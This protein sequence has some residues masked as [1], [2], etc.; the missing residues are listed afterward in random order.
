[1]ETYR[2]ITCK[3]RSTTPFTVSGKTITGREGK[4][5]F[6]PLKDAMVNGVYVKGVTL[7]LLEDKPWNHNVYMYADPKLHLNIDQDTID[8]NKMFYSSQITGNPKF[9]YD[10][11]YVTLKKEYEGLKYLTEKITTIWSSGVNQLYPNEILYRLGGHLN[12]DITGYC[13][14]T[15]DYYD[16]TIFQAVHQ[17]SEFIQSKGS[18]RRN[19]VKV[20]GLT[21]HELVAV[22]TTF[23]K[24]QDAIR[25]FI[26]PSLCAKRQ[27][28]LGNGH[29]DLILKRWRKLSALDSQFPL[30]IDSDGA[31]TFSSHPATPCCF[32]TIAW[33]TICLAIVQ[34]AKYHSDEIII[35]VA[36]GYKT[37]LTR[38]ILKWAEQQCTTTEA[39][40][41]LQKITRYVHN[42]SD[43]H[44]RILTE[45]PLPQRM[46]YYE[47][48][49][50]DKPYNE[51]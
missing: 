49:Y 6:D 23:W 46:R 5:E 17:L 43:E 40:E 38:D 27:P 32:R 51:I 10:K 26:P 14:K 16:P 29:D 13:V 11:P 35:S 12:I 3:L 33:L 37:S 41:L 15:K 7:E 28:F 47:D 2:D 22:Y 30:T 20:Q 19:F 42:E 45:V 39:T 36:M 1:M 8:R 21:A 9:V 31:V 48:N 25:E 18:Y 44:I 50:F 34:Y 24:V 4:F